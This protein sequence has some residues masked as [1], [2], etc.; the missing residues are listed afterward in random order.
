MVYKPSIW[1][2]SQSLQLYTCGQCFNNNTIVKTLTIQ[3]LLYCCYAIKIFIFC[4]VAFCFALLFLYYPYRRLLT[5]N[6]LEK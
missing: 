4:L 6:K 1:F 5:L 2:A 3:K